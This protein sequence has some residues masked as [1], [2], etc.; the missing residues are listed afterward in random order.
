[1]FFVGVDLGGT[2]IATVLIDEKGKIIKETIRRTEAKKGSKFVIKNMEES[3]Y[4]VCSDISFKKVAGIGFG[5]PGLVD[6]EKGMSIFAGNLGWRNIPILKK[7]KEKFDVPI[8]MDNDVR[9]ATLGEKYFGAGQGIDN[10]ICITL[11]TGI[12]SGIIID[13]KLYRGSS[14]TAGE[15][16]HVTICK[17]GLYCN[18]GNRGCLEVY[19]SAPGISRRARQYI[20]AGHYTI[21]TSMVDGDLSKITPKL[22]SEAYDLNDNLAHLIMDETAQLLAIGIAD[23]I[24]IINPEMIVIGGGVSLAGDRLFKPLRKY[25]VKRSMN[26]IAKNVEIVPAK[27]KDK[28]GMMGA[29]ALAMLNLGYLQN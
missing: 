4:E 15:I 26:Q 24:D 28:S 10:M 21:L 12:G 3:I 6:I 9:V 18:C 2:N 5:I 17:D 11:G 8:F 19:A 7:I 27:L 13:G 1:M 23:Y 22:I 25:V 16:G 20:K 14:H 29:A